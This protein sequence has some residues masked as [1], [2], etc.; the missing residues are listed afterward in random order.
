MFI[1]RERLCYGRFSWQE[2]YGAFSYSRSQISS[3]YKYIDNQEET[4]WLKTFK[5]EY[6]QHLKKREME[7]DEQFLYDFWENP[8]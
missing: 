8:V 5:D 2:G 3:I 7:F 1:N 4:H 6:I